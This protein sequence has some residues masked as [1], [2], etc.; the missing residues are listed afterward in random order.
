[1]L[2][3]D[4]F[5]DHAMLRL[6]SDSYLRYWFFSLSIISLFSFRAMRRWWCF[7]LFSMITLRHAFDFFDC[8]R[9]RCS[10]Y[11]FRCRYAD[12]YVCYF[13]RVRCRCW[14]CRAIFGLLWYAAAWWRHVLWFSPITP[15]RRWYAIA[16]AFII[17][18]FISFHFSIDHFFYWFSAAP[19]DDDFHFFLHYVLLILCLFR[20]HAI[21]AIAIFSSSISSA[22][23]C[24]A[25]RCF[26]ILM[27]AT[28]DTLSDCHD[29]D[30]WYFAD[31]PCWYLFSRLLLLFAAAPSDIL[32]TPTFR[33]PIAFYFCRFSLAF[34]RYACFFCARR[35]CRTLPLRMLFARAMPLRRFCA[36][37]TYAFLRSS[38]LALIRHFRYTR[39]FLLITL[40][41]LLID[42]RAFHCWLS[43]WTL[44]TI[45]CLMLFRYDPRY[46]LPRC[47]FYAMRW[48]DMIYCH[49]SFSIT[50][51][52][53][54]YAADVCARLFHAI[55]P[56][57]SLRLVYFSSPLYFMPSLIDFLF[58]IADTDAFRFSLADFFTPWFRYS[59]FFACCF[60]YRLPPFFFCLFFSLLWCWWHYFRRLFLYCFILR[61]FRF[62]ALIRLP[63][64]ID[65]FIL[66]MLFLRYA[67]F[68]FIFLLFLCFH[69]SCLIFRLLFI[70]RITHALMIFD[71]AFYHAFF[72]T[73]RH[74]APP[75][76]WCR[77]FFFYFMPL[78]LRTPL[79]AIR[80]DAMT[81]P[82]WYFDDL[83]LRWLFDT[84]SISCVRY[85]APPL[86][87]T[88]PILRLFFMPRYF[89]MLVLLARC[90]FSWCHAFAFFDWCRRFRFLRC[91]TISARHLR[92]YSAA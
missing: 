62:R 6:S 59:A 71:D 14:H 80:H 19:S 24:H 28:D 45:C 16:A 22:M 34:L 3:F 15:F 11:D 35:W 66:L 27:P 36:P 55:T 21:C 92:A 83:S 13:C 29:A 53:A 78:S 37:P 42:A 52:F 56:L 81:P 68:A 64:I 5:A 18:D 63:L 75:Y 50:L 61:A 82:D 32:F 48:H 60:S 25:T 73:M 38:R 1:M 26:Y 8:C 30:C 46:F 58:F 74:F 44:L 49:I 72:F 41:S 91:L 4:A 77:F 88:L 40:L 89:I 9:L 10:L 23:I 39:R 79:I 86:A 65:C 70:W 17:F 54:A 85:A 7:A 12:Y 51:S 33:A 69:F 47:Y 67:L 84:F 57:F 90:R 43:R 31:T 76:C 2:H 20:C 87:A